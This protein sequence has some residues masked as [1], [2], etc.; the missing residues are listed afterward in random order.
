MR[1]E[2]Q[3]QFYLRYYADPSE[4][5]ASPEEVLMVRA[6]LEEKYEMQAH[7]PVPKDKEKIFAHLVAMQLILDRRAKELKGQSLADGTDGAQ[8]EAKAMTVG[9]TRV[10]FGRSEEGAVSD[11][12]LNQDARMTNNFNALWRTLIAT[13]RRFRRW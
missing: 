12:L 13:T 4:Y 8:T 10:E 5:M 3:V 11:A 2:E 1:F 7:R 6:F 9:D